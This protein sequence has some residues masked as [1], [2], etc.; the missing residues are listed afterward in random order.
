MDLKT[1][2]LRTVSTSLTATA[3]LALVAAPAYAQDYVVQPGDTVTAIARGHGVSVSTIVA[4]NNLDARATIYAGQHLTLPDGSATPVAASAPKTYV[5]AKGDTLWAIATRFH[6]SVAALQLAN[7]MANS[8][9]IRI[10]EAL[11]IPGGAAASLA[12]SNTMAATYVVQLGDTLWSIAQ[13]L[14]TSVAGLAQLNGVANPSLI[15][16]N[17]PLTI[18]A[19]A[20]APLVSTNGSTSALAPTPASTYIVVRGDTLSGIAARFGTSVSAIASANAMTNP[21]IIRTG[22][23]LTIP[24]GV[25]TG[26]VGDTFLGYTYPADVVAAANVNKATLN[27]MDVPSRVQ[28]Q[29]LVI[30]T[31]NAMG[32]DPALAQAIAYQESGFNQRAVSSANA[33][34]CMQVIPTSGEWASGLVGRPLNL[35]IAQDNAT[36]GVAILRQLLRNGTPVETAIAGYYQGE[37]SVRQRGLNPDTRQYVASVVTLMAR[38]K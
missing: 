19:G 9:L 3:A 17:Q 16:V 15:R 27:A 2:G 28:M 31:A 21:S 30:D 10:G 18:P 32:V 22:Q 8:T 26:L 12:P 7:G 11:A 4:S 23:S 35:L 37:L 24:G 33:L 34:G 20:T 25:P 14:G 6:T 38:F 1:A 5:V 13:K 29:Q 36:A